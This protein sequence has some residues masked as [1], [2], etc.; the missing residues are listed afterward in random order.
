MPRGALQPSS[1]SI[2]RKATIQPLCVAQRTVMECISSNASN[3]CSRRHCLKTLFHQRPAGVHPPTR[4][5]WMPYL[6]WRRRVI[7]MRVR[8]PPN[9]ILAHW[10]TTCQAHHVSRKQSMFGR[11]NR[12]H[13][14]DV[15]LGTVSSTVPENRSVVSRLPASV[16]RGL[17]NTTLTLLL[18]DIM[19][20]G[21]C[22]WS[23]RHVMMGS[24]SAGQAD[25]A[26][27]QFE[28]SRRRSSNCTT[29]AGCWIR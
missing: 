18:A 23:A 17:P 21:M 26:S 11:R 24:R 7:E 14:D 5:S 1:H 22:A 8:F 16:A 25:T 28:C 6:S 9:H 4:A 29:A 19:Q 20:G 13:R 12:P 15:L 3:K 10:C 27:P 2:C